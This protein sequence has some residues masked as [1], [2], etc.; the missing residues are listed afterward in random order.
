VICPHG[1]GAGCEIC[2]LRDVVRQ[3]SE[4]TL[5]AIDLLSGHDRVRGWERRA[6]AAIEYAR[7]LLNPKGD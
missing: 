1:A 3:L 5:N 2:R 4:V 7:Q 6:H